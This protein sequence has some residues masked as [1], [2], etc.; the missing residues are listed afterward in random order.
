MWLALAFFTAFVTS[1][2]DVVAK[3]L[4]KRVSPYV[5]AWA[6]MF[7]SVPVFGLVLIGQKPVVVGPGFWPALVGTTVVLTLS[8]VLMFKAIGSADLSQSVP[9]LSLTPLFLLVTSPIIVGEKP[10]P[11]GILGVVLIVVGSYRLFLD[12]SRGGFWAPFRTLLRERGSRYMLIVAFLA[13]IGGNLDKV[14]V[15]NSSPA[16]W[17]LA[18]HSAASAT[19]G[20]IM[21]FKIPDAGEQICRHW[22]R[23]A[24]LGT[25]LGVMMITQMIAIL[26]TQVPYLIAIKRTSVIMSSLWGFWFFK[27]KAA[28]RR[29]W[30]VLLMVAGVFVIAFTK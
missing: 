23:L 22:R 6:W 19:L 26:M 30:A 27:E 14:G 2:Q 4:S 15:I 24:L 10:H 29:L 11:M 28:G 16:A 7:F 12:P 21:L 17:G 25:L 13:S 5:T 3:T 9:L 18:V 20:M 8:S 1:L